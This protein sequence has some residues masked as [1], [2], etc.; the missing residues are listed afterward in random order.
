[1]LVEHTRLK[2][3]VFLF[4]EPA[5]LNVIIIHFILFIYFLYRI[6]ILF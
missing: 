2:H 6:E 1:M 3:T 5:E 4:V